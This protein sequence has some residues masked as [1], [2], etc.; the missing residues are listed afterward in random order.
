MEMGEI[1]KNLRIANGLTQEE[2][3]IKAGTTKQTIYKYET[4]IISNIPSDKITK[5]AKALKTTPAYIMGYDTE[6][7]KEDCSVD[8]EEIGAVSEELYMKNLYFEAA[9][10]VANVDADRLPIVL[11]LL[12]NAGFHI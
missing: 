12:K 2:L 7:L 6:F 3:A 5:L 10:L 1:I 4:G 11:N 9:K 8:T